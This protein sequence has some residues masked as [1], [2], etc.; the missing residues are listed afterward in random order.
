M[1]MNLSNEQYETADCLS[2]HHPNSLNVLIV[3]LGGLGVV[4]LTQKVRNLVSG[5]YHQ[6]HTTEQRG[7]AQR[8][9]S[10]S[11]L[12]KASDSYVSPTLSNVEIDVMIALEPLEALRYSHMLKAGAKC[13]L[14]DLRIETIGGCQGQFAYPDT[15]G[16][17]D[18]IS[19]KGATCHLLPI[20]DWLKED[21]MLAVHASSAMLGCFCA[22]FGFV[23]RPANAEKSPAQQKNQRAFE[24]GFRQYIQQTTHFINPP[25]AASPI[26]VDNLHPAFAQ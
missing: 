21:A 11:A 18:S 19:A 6:V 3:G 15:T 4:S 5:R 9:A 10:T 24:W 2:L 12:I 23:D 16:I 20:S 14:S 22:A 8:R 17:V 13:F 1:Y 26:V 25:K 7:V